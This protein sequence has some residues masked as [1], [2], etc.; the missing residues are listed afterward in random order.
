MSTYSCPDYEMDFLKTYL[1]FFPPVIAS[2]AFLVTFLVT[3]SSIIREKESKMKEYLRLIGVNPVVIWLCWVMRS[4]SIYLV[5]SIILTITSTMKFDKKIPNDLSSKKALFQNTDPL[6]IFLTFFIY[7]IQTTSLS[8]LIS[9]IFS[10]RNIFIN[11]KKTFEL[12]NYSLF[13]FLN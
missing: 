9:Q 1:Q 2:F 7:S 11:K 5:L 12:F 8:L 6:L 13:D 3:I 10:K 4:F